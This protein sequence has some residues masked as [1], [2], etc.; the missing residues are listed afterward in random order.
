V[1]AIRRA[2]AFG[3]HPDDV[4]PQAG[5]TLAAWAARGARVNATDRRPEADAAHR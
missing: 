1:P 5:G 2:P 4:E 3:A